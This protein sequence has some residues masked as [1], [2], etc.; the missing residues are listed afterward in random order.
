MDRRWPV[1]DGYVDGDL[2]CVVRDGVSTP[3]TPMEVALFEAL[4]TAP[5][6]VVRRDELLVNVWGFPKVVRTRAVDHAVSRLRRKVERDASNPEVLVGVRGV[7]YRYVSPDGTI[8]GLVGRRSDWTRLSAA[9]D[10]ASW[11]SVIG[12]PGVGKRALVRAWAEQ[13]G[14]PHIDARGI[15]G[16]AFWPHVAEAL[17]VVLVADMVPA[18]QLALAVQRADVDGL[19]LSHID[20]VQPEARRLHDALGGHP[21]MLASS[22]TSPRSRQ[23]IKAWP[24]SAWALRFNR[25]PNFRPRAWSPVRATAFAASRLKSLPGIR[26]PILVSPVWAKLVPSNR[27]CRLQ[28]CPSTRS[29]R[30]RAYC[31][32]VVEIGILLFGH[33]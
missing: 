23:V 6:R 18:V 19:A 4:A 22:R 8:H 25:G 1:W 26:A 32:G 20:E 28:P 31:A 2:A 27:C 16:E 5:D 21:S 33:K 24:S 3:L 11:V 14:W 17:G 9:L 29:M 13:H 30:I 12:P 7:G 15:R 10:G